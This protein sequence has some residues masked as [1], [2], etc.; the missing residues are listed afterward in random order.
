MLEV[1]GWWIVCGV[2]AF[3]L[4]L[5]LGLILSFLRSQAASP[6]GLFRKSLGEMLNPWREEDEALDR[7]AR[8]VEALQ[9]T[10]GQEESDENE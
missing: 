8:D 3:V 2:L 10:Q 5:N 9:D 6:K 7:L 1:N 4:M